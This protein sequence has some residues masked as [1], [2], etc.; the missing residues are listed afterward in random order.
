MSRLDELAPDERAAL[1][2]LLRQK[3]S[4]EDL[5]GMLDVEP[6]LVRERARVACARL[7]REDL[8]APPRDE[9]ASVVDFLLGQLD[10]AAVEI[11]LRDD[12]TSNWA[13]AVAQQLRGLSEVVVERVE[14]PG[15]EDERPW[16]AGE[17]EAEAR[18]AGRRAWAPDLVL[19][20]VAY[21]T[22]IVAGLT[23]FIVIGLTH[24]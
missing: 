9:Q 23:A 21:V 19:P 15:G 5:G 14:R 18:E 24:H 12:V 16:E 4:Y 7:V 20:F 2:L 3:L 13:R 22:V 1:E 8:P 11:D 17:R 6:A 10:P